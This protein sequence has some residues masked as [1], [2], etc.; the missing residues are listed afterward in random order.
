MGVTSSGA[1]CAIVAA[2]SAHPGET[3]AKYRSLAATAL[4]A[5]AVVSG[6]GGDDDDDSASP[7]ICSEADDLKS[8]LDDLKNVDIVENG[9]SS[10]DAALDEVKSDATALSESAKSEFGPEVQSLEDAL[11]SLGSAITSVGSNGLQPVSDAVSAVEDSA[12]KLV[13]D[14]QSEKCS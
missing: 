2:T 6:C 4:L 11:S 12:T 5:M 13:D 8:S 9:V 7:S 10:L 3:V 14:V 1:S